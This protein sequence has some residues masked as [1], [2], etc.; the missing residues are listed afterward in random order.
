VGWLLVGSIGLGAWCLSIAVG[1]GHAL[2]ARLMPRHRAATRLSAAF[3]LGAALLSY[4]VLGLGLIGRLRPAPLFGLLALA[5]LPCALTWRSIA[6]LFRVVMT[7]AWTDFRAGAGPVRVLTALT[8]ALVAMS[9]VVPLLPVT[10]ADALAYATA[11]PARFARDGAVLFY[12][13]SYESAFV[14]LVEQLHAIGYV[15]ALRPV[16][17]WFEVAAQLLVFLAAADCYRAVAGDERP[18]SAY[19][20]GAALL[21]VP[22][23][24]LMPFMAK[25]HLVEMLAIIVVMTTV[26]EAPDRGGWAGAAACAGVCIATKYNAGLGLAALVAPATLVAAWRARHD[27]RVVTLFGAVG[28]LLLLGSPPYVRNWLWTGNP[29]F[30]MN[31]PGFDSPYHLRHQDDWIASLYY[32]DSGFGRR[33]LDLL[34]WWPR[35]AVLPIRGS[36]SYMGTFALSF[37]PLALVRPRARHALVLLTGVA[38]ST[39]ALFVLGAQFERYFIAPIVGMTTLAVA[40]WD[41]RRRR[42]ASIGWAGVALLLFLGLCVTLPQ[43]AYGLL[44]QVPALASRAREAQVIEQT[45]PWYADFVRI[46]ETVAPGSPVLCLLRTCQYL[47]VYRRED[48]FF[49]LVEANE[50]PP[51]RIDPRPVHEGLLAQ[52]LRYIVALD[53]LA[54]GRAPVSVVDWL[55]VCGGR[56]VYHNAQA[57]FGTRDPRR[58]RTG[59]LVLIELTDTLAP[60]A[61]S[62]S[63]RC[64][65]P[66]TAW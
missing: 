63:G 22:L 1:L 4:S 50:G 58:V 59:G 44:V 54:D 38:S 34:L 60:D 25:A 13:D 29:V 10:N 11:A 66:T 21:L 64:A 33:P 19:V 5:T 8:L 27:T 16:G 26:L 47:V 23:T 53:S 12:S 57:R 15:F 49:R 52:G 62:L 46:R 31:V 32:L 6:A 45:T 55:R 20:C 42:S 17:V 36:A 41:G 56:L 2:A 14:L 61:A 9:P 7:D 40:G 39:V 30:P 18:G 24:Q 51:G 37:L 3:L 65:M 35:A 28:W 43:K 48:A